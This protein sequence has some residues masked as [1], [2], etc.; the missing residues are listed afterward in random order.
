MEL[1]YPAAHSMD[2]RWYAID[3]DGHVASFYSGEA[4]AVPMAATVIEN[5]YHMLEQ[6]RELVPVGSVLFDPAGRCQP[7]REDAIPRAW[8]G[9]YPVL[10]F[11]SSLQPA[12]A[13]LE[14]GRAVEVAATEG[15]AVLLSSLSEEELNRYHALP[16]FRGSHNLFFIQGGRPHELAQ[17][18]LYEYNHL[19]ENW[20]SGPYGREAV[21]AQ[22]LHIDQLPPALRQTLARFRLDKI[23]FADTL[24]FQPVEHTECISWESGYLDVDCKRIRP[25]P[26]REEEYGETFEEYFGNSEYEAEPPSSA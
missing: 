7:G 18:G 12:T 19:T 14:S 1:D 24:Y 13:D 2:T 20:I 11:L 21:P 9:D 15:K 8:T 10:L 3:R 16:E 4:G 22:P 26:G 6:L 23:R 25:I 17:H 5:E